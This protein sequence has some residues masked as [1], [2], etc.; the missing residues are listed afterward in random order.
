M[1]NF[2]TP[3]LTQLPN[4]VLSLADYERL[5]PN[6]MPHPVFEYI[7]GGCGDDIT[8]NSNTSAF[9]RWQILP[10]VLQDFADANTH[11]TWLQQVMPHPIALA[12]VAYQQLVHP[13]GEVASAKAA[14]AMGS[15][16]VTSTLS[17]VSMEELAP[18][19]QARWFQLYWQTNRKDTLQLVK[20]AEVCGYQAIV[21]TVDVP[22]NGLRHRP[23][24]AGFQLPPHI[25]AANLT[26]YNNY[27]LSSHSSRGESSILHGLMAQAPT[28]E[29]IAWLRQQTALP[30]IL[31]GVLNPR[32]AAHAKELQMNGVIVSNHGGRSIDGAPNSIDMLSDIRQHMGND[33][34]ILLDS[35]VRRGTDIFKALALGANGVLLGRPVMYG[36]AVAGALGVAHSIKLL[37]EELEMTMALAG[38][39]TLQSITSDYLRE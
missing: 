31:K 30:L 9:D 18:H 3:K 12:P 37:L 38:C 8:R 34:L 36:L 25:T 23:Q 17:S 28:W 5:A 14:S 20:R 24:K 39:P 22:V 13:D 29:D 21:F 10:Q 19:T 2:Y 7:D 32:D 11:C 35:G 1:N 4:D 6:F 15:L 26:P 33:A 16:Y 27:S